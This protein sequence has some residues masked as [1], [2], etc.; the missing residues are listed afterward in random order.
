MSGLGF[1]YLT[2]TRQCLYTFWRALSLIYKLSAEEFCEEFCEGGVSGV[3]E[4]EGVD[5]GAFAVAAC[6]ISC[7][8]QGDPEPLKSRFTLA[9]KLREYH[10]PH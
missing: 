1:L 3:V 9:S 5:E 8:A 2:I 7:H 6:D 10:R 4:S